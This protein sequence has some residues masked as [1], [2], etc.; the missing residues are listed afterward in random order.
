[1]D[2]KCA[3]AIY[4]VENE[5]DKIKP[6]ICKVTNKKCVCCSNNG[7]GFK[8]NGW[9]VDCPTF[10]EIPHEEQPYIIEVIVEKEK[11]YNPNYG[12]DRMC[13]CGHSYYRHFDSYENM[14]ACGCK[15]CGCYDFK[16]KK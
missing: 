10:V 4:I 15:Y 16:E 6:I 3:N 5:E 14:N 13:K 7:L 2:L 12:D 11:K 1:M 9:V 8:M